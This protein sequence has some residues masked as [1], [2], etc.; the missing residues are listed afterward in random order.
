L[1][2]FSGDEPNAILSFCS[3][4]A[5]WFSPDESI[6]LDL[7]HLLIEAKQ[8][9]P[10]F[11]ATL[12]SDNEQYLN[13]GGEYLEVVAAVSKGEGRKGGYGGSAYRIFCFPSMTKS[14]LFGFLC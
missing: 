9:V 12:Q 2:A 8:R 1:L 13:I 10:A 5:V 4:V 3:F 14:G 6:L 11:L 7:K